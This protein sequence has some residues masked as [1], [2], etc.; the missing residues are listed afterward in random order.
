[1]ETLGEVRGSGTLPRVGNDAVHV[2]LRM[3]GKNLNGELQLRRQIRK[4]SVGVVKT[5]NLGN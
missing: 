3:L 1:M 5:W 4:S 2:S